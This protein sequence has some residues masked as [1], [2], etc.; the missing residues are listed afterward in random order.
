MTLYDVL[1]VTPAADDATVRRAYVSLARQ[2]HPDREG[3]DADRMRAINNAWATLGD[4][5]AR[6]RYDQSLGESAA[7]P[8]QSAPGSAWTVPPRDNLDERDEWD[9]R[10]LPGIVRLPGWLSMVPVGLFAG[11]VVLFVVGLVFASQPLLA[12]ALMALMLST[13]FFLAAPFV[14]LLAS[15]MGNGRRHVRR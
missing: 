12:V 10:P 8:R 15:R 5:A 4:R 3:G 1:G 9:D 11:A 7:Q 2:H 14:A 13:L 6:A